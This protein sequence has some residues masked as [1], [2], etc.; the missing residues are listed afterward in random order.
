MLDNWGLEYQIFRMSDRSWFSNGSGI[1]MFG[2]RTLAVYLNDLELL[3][4]SLHNF[5]RI[6]PKEIDS[7][8]VWNYNSLIC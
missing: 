8:S 7:E 6:E 2:Y 3:I 4:H 1:G 5:F